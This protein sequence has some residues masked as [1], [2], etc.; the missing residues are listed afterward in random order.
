MYGSIISAG[1]KDSWES[2]HVEGVGIFGLVYVGWL[3]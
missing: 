2:K 1:T 3:A